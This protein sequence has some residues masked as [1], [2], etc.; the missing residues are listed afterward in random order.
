VT[1]VWAAVFSNCPV[2]QVAAQVVPVKNVVPHVAQSLVVPYKHVAHVVVTHVGIEVGVT[3]EVAEQVVEATG[4]VAA[5]VTPESQFPL[6]VAPTVPN[7]PAF[8]IQKIACPQFNTS[9]EKP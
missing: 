8:C 2:G 6:V 9:K 4:Q 5:V 7:W 3:T 1:Q